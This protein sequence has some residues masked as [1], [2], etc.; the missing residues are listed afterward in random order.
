[1]RELDDAAVR[2]RLDGSQ[3]CGGSGGDLAAGDA[4][5]LI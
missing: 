5:Y 2:S 4:S 1:M 3:F